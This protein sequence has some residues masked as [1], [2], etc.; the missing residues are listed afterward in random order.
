MP[1]MNGTELFERLR[2]VMP[3]MKVLFMSGYQR[4]VISSH[5]MM[6]EERDLLTKPFTGQALATRVREILDRQTPR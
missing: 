5:I 3:D 4:D 6:G 2:A 1:R